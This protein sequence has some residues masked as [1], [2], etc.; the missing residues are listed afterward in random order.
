MVCAG[1]V[2]ARQAFFSFR[3]YR[4]RFKNPPCQSAPSNAGSTRSIGASSPQSFVLRAP[5]GAASDADAPMAA[6]SY[7]SVMAVGS[8]R[9]A[10]SG[11]MMPADARAVCRLLT[12]RSRISYV[13]RTS[14]SRQYRRGRHASCWQALIWIMTQ[15]TMTPA[16]SP[17][18]ANDAIWRMI[19]QNIAG[20]A[21]GPCFGA[22]RWVI[23]S[24]ASTDRSCRQQSAGASGLGLGRA[25]FGAPPGSPGASK[26]SL[27]G[28]LAFCRL[29][30]SDHSSGRHAILHP[31]SRTSGI[32]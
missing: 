30:H 6:T 5:K 10:S 27:L 21:G 18:C 29:H 11:A 17:H 13:S 25:I 31:P 14:W 1:K 7:T 9:S 16:I 3:S 4:Q 26:C 23:S 20:S 28:K 12:H 22:A 32:G 15:A 24:S 19:V 2:V 8:T